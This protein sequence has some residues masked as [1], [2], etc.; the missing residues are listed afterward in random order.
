MESPH[1][2]KSALPRDC[3]NGARAWCGSQ[4]H[5]TG[6]VQSRRAKVGAERGAVAPELLVDRPNRAPERAGDLRRP[7]SG[8]SEPALHIGL[9][10]RH[11]VRR[12]DAAGCRVEQLQNRVDHG[13]GGACQA[14]SRGSREHAHLGPE[15]GADPATAQGVIESLGLGETTPHEGLRNTQR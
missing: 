2:G 7:E 6:P 3:R 13:G 12:S 8:S 9:H 5:L 14:R 4:E 1:V 15:E 10:G 11:P